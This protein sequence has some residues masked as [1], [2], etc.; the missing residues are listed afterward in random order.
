MSGLHADD[1]HAKSASRERRGL[2]PRAR[3]DSFASTLTI[4]PDQAVYQI[5]EPITLNV[6]GDAEGAD[7][8]GVCGRIVFDA[9]LAG[10]VASHQEQLRSFGGRVPWYL[11]PLGR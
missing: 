8:Y 10:Y 2:G 7:I 4:T 11:V 3:A 5:G 9:D 1:C 6:V